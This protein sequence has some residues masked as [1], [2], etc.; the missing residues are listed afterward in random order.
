MSHLNELTLELL[1]SGKISVGDAENFLRF[2]NNNQFNN[3]VSQ[4]DRLVKLI[5]NM[6]LGLESSNVG[7]ERCYIHSNCVGK[8]IA[9]NFIDIFEPFQ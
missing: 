9:D 4:R 6:A 1:D 7:R 8:K 2:V 3:D 5:A